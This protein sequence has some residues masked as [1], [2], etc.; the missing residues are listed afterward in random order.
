MEKDFLYYLSQV[1]N[2]FMTFTMKIGDFIK[3][4]KTVDFLGVEVIL[5]RGVPVV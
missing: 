5:A 3:T 4:Q 1:K 2:S